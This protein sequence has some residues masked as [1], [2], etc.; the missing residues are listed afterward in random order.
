MHE[1]ENELVD[2]LSSSD[3]SLSERRGTKSSSC[4]SIAGFVSL[5]I[6]DHEDH[7][8]WE[9]PAYLSCSSLE[10]GTTPNCCAN[11]RLVNIPV[12]STIFPS[13]IRRIPIH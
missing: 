7:R 13:A 10:A 1:S 4:T 6:I 3:R 5:V 9:Q 11:S 2:G 12:D 8:V